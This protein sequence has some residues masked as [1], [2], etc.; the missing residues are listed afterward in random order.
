MQDC[1]KFH[2][3]KLSEIF[4]V[5]LL[6]INNLISVNK[7]KSINYNKKC[8]KSSLL[9]KRTPNK[10]VFLKDAESTVIS[11]RLLPT[12]IL[13]IPDD[14]CLFNPFIPN[15]LFYFH[16]SDWSISSIRGVWLFFYYHAL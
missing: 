2:L 11:V 8:Q 3:F 9:R 5:L 16:S 7:I 14:L 4:T 13:V 10:N 15:G 6:N 12:I 1:S